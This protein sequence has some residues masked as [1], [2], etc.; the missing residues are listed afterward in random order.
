MKSKAVF[1]CDSFLFENLVQRQ[2]SKKF[3]QQMF[4]P[5]R[6]TVVAFDFHQLYHLKTSIQLP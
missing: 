2:K 4:D 6:K 5:A 1:F 3:R